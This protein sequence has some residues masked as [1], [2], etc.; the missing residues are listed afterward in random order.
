MP[1][2]VIESLERKTASNGIKLQALS[3]GLAALMAVSERQ[4]VLISLIMQKVD[5]TL[6]NKEIDDERERLD[7][8]DTPPQPHDGSSTPEGN[9]I[10]PA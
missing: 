7:K 1:P 5:I 6:T 8:K 10:R 2:S 3:T 9:T 4:V